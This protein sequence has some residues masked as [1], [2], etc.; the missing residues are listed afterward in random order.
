MHRTIEQ[1]N[2]NGCFYDNNDVTNM[3]NIVLT[4]LGDN[5]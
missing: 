1:N 2:G 4:I 5:K 3:P